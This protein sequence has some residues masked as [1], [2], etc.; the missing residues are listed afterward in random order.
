[1]FK[2]NY[3]KFLL[4]LDKSDKTKLKLLILLLIF[5]LALEAMGLGVLLGFITLLTSDQNIFFDSNLFFN[6]ISQN[7]IDL[8]IFF[9]ILILLMYLLK[10]FLLVYLTYR[11]NRFL[12]SLVKKITKQLYIE[13]LK[14]EIIND[15]ETISD[16]I[17]IIFN[18]TSM[19]YT[20]L[21]SLLTIIVDFIF[22]L[23]VI[24]ILIIIEPLGSLVAGLIFLLFA[25]SYNKIS[26]NKIRNLGIQRERND[27]ELFK[28]VS[29][30]LN[31]IYELHLFKAKKYFEFKFDE[32]NKSKYHYFS[33]INTFN[34][35]PRYY[36]ETV[37]LIGISC[38]ILILLLRDENIS[39]IIS[40][41]GVFVAGSLRMIPSLNRI[42]SSLQ[43]LK[44][45]LPSFELISDKILNKID[46]PI[47]NSIF[48]NDYKN[49]FL[50]LKNLSFNYPEE[51][52]FENLNLIIDKGDK[53]GIY[54]NS[55]VG[56]STLI[57]LLLGNLKPSS[58]FILNNGID[59][60]SNVNNW[61]EKISTFNQ[62][63]FIFN[64]SLEFNITF[65]PIKLIDKKKLKQ[66]LK[67]SQ[68]ENFS[69]ELKIDEKGLNMS[70]GQNQ[71][72][73][74]ARAIYKDFEFLILDEPTSSLDDETKI[75]VLQGIFKHF[76]KKTIILI[77]H[78]METLKFCNK[79]FELK[80]GNLIAK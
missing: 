47:L 64:E 33:L 61:I 73:S 59:I 78:D 34:Q 56:K 14:I 57:K 1:M 54:G 48:F 31:G 8:K 43:Q 29:E 6:K 80:S 26:N 35:I 50:T 22:V 21:T 2:K 12:S 60:H 51:K 71:R 79:R 36:Y 62:N 72:I 40:T 39:N 18:E 25:I 77:S 32:K 28:I 74:I 7:A 67:I 5:S 70:G 17:K 66:A 58:G 27:K 37:S 15:K 10:L 45:Y 23:F 41:L 16:K 76:S 3:F 4:L 38:F 75:K 55:G 53:I 19:F 69:N 9:L 11:Q 20:F 63:T 24:S 68:L 30:S 44:I 42:T 65:E 49:R 52:V 46:K 13:S